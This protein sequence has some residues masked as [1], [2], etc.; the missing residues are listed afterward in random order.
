MEVVSFV[1]GRVRLKLDI[2]RKNN[3][4]SQGFKL[5]F[6]ELEGVEGVKVN[7]IIGTVALKYNPSIIDVNTLKSKVSSIADSNGKYLEYISEDYKDYLKEERNLQIAKNKMLIFGS[8]YLLYKIKQYFFGKFFIGSSLPVLKVAAAITLIKGYPQLK[9]SYHKIG[10]YFPT[11]PDKLLLVAGTAL[12]LSREGNKGTMLLFLKAFTDALQ[13]YSRLQIMRILIEN[14]G[15]HNSLVWY[16]HNENQYLLPIQYLEEGDVVTFHQNDTI[17]VDGIIMEGNALINHLYYSGQPEIKRVRKNT[18]VYD[19]MVVVSGNIKV[20]VKRIPDKAPK[21]DLILNSLNIGKRVKRYQEKSL[22]FASAL[23]LLSLMITGSSLAALSVLLLMTPSAS[24]VALNAGIANY[25]KLLMKNKIIL[26]NINTI[27]N[28]VNANSIVFDKTG[29]LTDG[30]LRIGKIEIYDDKYTQEDIIQIAA[31]CEGNI[32]HPVASAFTKGKEKLEYNNDTIYIPSK[33][34]ISNYKSHRVV[35]GNARLMMK[36]KFSLV[37]EK[38]SKDKQLNYYIPIYFAVDHKLRA[39]ILLI[40][41]MEVN[42]PQLIRQ[43]KGLGINDISIIS[44]DLKRNTENIAN[45]LGVKNY[46]GGLSLNDKVEYI[47]DKRKNNTVIMVGDGINDTLAMEEADVSISFAN[48]ASQHTILK[49]DCLLMEKDLLLV[50]RLI[51]I[52]EKSYYKIQRN[53]DFSQ[54]YN[55]V[56][57]ILAAFGYVGPFKA[58][59]LNTFNSILSIFNSI[60]VSSK[61]I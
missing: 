38:K 31:S 60:R 8:I 40:E 22:Y 4:L 18:N 26:R 43:I 49:S 10:K 12:T 52:T 19:G 44:G 36:E 50:A 45:S 56:F 29:T 9:A 51:E 20:K 34:I 47:K 53:I 58:K 33:G 30:N 1:P 54:N 6:K 11:N 2:I 27:E 23:A 48:G 3:E 59:S 5:Y 46:I 28:V 61:T 15:T 32:Y 14:K 24:K 21:S 16:N 13:S 57:G 55:Y 35:M 41:D 42:S 25:L 39:K 7:P 37:N 17:V